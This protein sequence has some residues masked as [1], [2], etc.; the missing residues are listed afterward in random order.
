MGA[1][2]DVIT[3]QH[4]LSGFIAG[5]ILPESVFCLSF[6]NRTKHKDGVVYDQDTGRAIDIYLQSGTG[7]NTKSVYNATHTVSREPINHQEDM[8]A[9]GKKLLI[10]CEFTSAALGSNE[11]QI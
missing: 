6:E 7:H 2:Y 8:R 5:D 11:K 3:T 9:V 1:K 10:D 4:P